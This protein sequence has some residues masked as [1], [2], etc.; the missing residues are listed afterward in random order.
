MNTAPPARR[1]R[2]DSRSTQTKE[3]AKQD[4]PKEVK[5]G[6]TNPK[7]QGN[8]R[9]LSPLGGGAFPHSLR[10]PPSFGGAAFLTLL[11]VVLPSSASFGWRGRTL[12]V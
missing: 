11:W 8:F 5:E 9:R 1:E 12:F 4:H 10:A 6:S 3:R 7:G 2:E